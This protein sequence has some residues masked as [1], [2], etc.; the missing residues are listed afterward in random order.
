LVRNNHQ[1]DERK[2]VRGWKE[3][4]RADGKVISWWRHFPDGMDVARNWTA[5]M[6]N[7]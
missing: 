1:E 6:Q 3:L 7:N 2:L 4:D 5:L